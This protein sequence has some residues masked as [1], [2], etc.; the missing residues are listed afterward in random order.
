[1]KP[2]DRPAF[3]EVVI[4][5]AELKGKQ[6][7]ASALQLYWRAMQ[8]WS[9]EDFRSAAEQLLRTCEFMPVPKDFEDLRKAGRKTAGE[10][11][12]AA[13]DASCQR[14]YPAPRPDGSYPI[15]YYANTCGDETID[16]V[17]EMIG[18]YETLRMCET[19]KLHFLE[20]RFVEHYEELR[21]VVETREALPHLAC[22]E[23]P[24]RLRTGGLKSVGE[25][26]PKLS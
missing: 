13:L 22:E 20:R 18:G 10:C 17:V 2:A 14:V 3:L 4:G 5:F 9:L 6:L 7:S 23:P 16:R 19:T 15:G 26:L 11:W 12:L 1:V 21:D 8:H 24:L 25:L